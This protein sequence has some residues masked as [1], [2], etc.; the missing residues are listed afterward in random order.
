MTQQF[1]LHQWTTSE[2]VDAPSNYNH[3]HPRYSTD[4]I[5]CKHASTKAVH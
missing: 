4:I 3:S 5:M 1:T 2:L